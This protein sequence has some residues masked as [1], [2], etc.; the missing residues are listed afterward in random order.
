MD[1]T[2]LISWLALAGTLLIVALLLCRLIQPYDI[3]W[4]LSNREDKSNLSKM[5]L[6][7]ANGYLM[8]SGSEILLG[9]TGSF[10]RFDSVDRDYR[11]QYGPV[12]SATAVPPWHRS[13]DD[14]DIPPQPLRP[15]P[16]PREAKMSR[17]K[18]IHRQ[19]SEPDSSA[20][21]IIISPI[22]RPVPRKQHSAPLSF[23]LPLLGSPR[24]KRTT[25]G[26]VVPSPPVHAPCTNPF[27]GGAPFTE[28][29]GEGL[30]PNATT[31]TPTKP[32][33]GSVLRAVT[34]APPAQLFAPSAA[35]PASPQRTAAHPVLRAPL[36]SAN[37]PFV[38]ASSTPTLLKQSIGNQTNQYRHQ[39][40]QQQQ[41]CVFSFEPATVQSLYTEDDPLRRA[42]KR[43]STMENLRRMSRLIES[44]QL[45]LNIYQ[46]FNRT[47]SEPHPEPPPSVGTPAP[48][49]PPPPQAAP[50]AVPGGGE[51]ASNA[52]RS[53]PSV[54]LANER[55]PPGPAAG[56]PVPPG[57][58]RYR[59]SPRTDAVDSLRVPSVSRSIK[60]ILR[61]R[62]FSETEFSERALAK[63][64]AM[65]SELEPPPSPPA[66]SMMKHSSY[67]DL[68]RYVPG[69]G[70]SG[71]SGR[72]EPSHGQRAA[73]E[74]LHKTVSESF[75]EQYSLLGRCD[76]VPPVR[77]GEPGSEPAGDVGGVACERFRTTTTVLPSSSCESV[78]S[79]SSVVFAD[80]TPSSLHRG[81]LCVALQPDR[82]GTSGGTEL[83]VTVQEAKDLVRPAGPSDAGEMETFV[84]VFMSTDKANAVQTKIC[85]GSSRPSYGETFRFRIPANGGTGRRQTLCFQVYQN[86]AQS[87]TLVGEA[88]AQINDTSQQWPTTTWLQLRDCSY[89]KG[90][91][92]GE[93]MF[94][95]SYLPTAER[96]TVVVVKA[97][98][99]ALKSR[100]VDNGRRGI[101]HCNEPAALDGP[102][103]AT[104][105]AGPDPECGGNIFVKVYLLQ[106]DQK[107][108]KK[109]TSAK[110]AEQFP[111]YNEAIIFSVPP[112][113]LNAV[114]IRLSV[115]QMVARAESSAFPGDCVD[116]AGYRRKPSVKLVSLGHVIIG[117]GTT[118][119]ALRHWHQ[120]LT[121]LR[122]PVAMWHGLRS[123]SERKQ[124]RSG[125]G[126]T[127]HKHDQLPA[128]A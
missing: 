92:L 103:A 66:A 24:E 18:P 59:D 22:P 52:D 112:Y 69:V 9:S 68:S 42:E 6:Y 90:S 15:A 80:L 124:S 3:A 13:T 110:R 77:P 63:T 127:D 36:H 113:L 4:F 98:N 17:D 96:L 83:A 26:P 71:S 1:T 99:I 10:R 88:E 89:Q 11:P 12:P 72:V 8:R 70:T 91:H 87:P 29:C 114:Q 5:R 100:I 120:M 49:T 105:I 126:G 46:Q 57:L 101:V 45:L 28:E 118:G 79:Q 14:P 107:V 64:L 23:P 111:I 81:Y 2:V 58:A 47:V 43:L 119:K 50:P 60:H 54:S 106:N 37:N 62:S 27:L 95:L 122:K 16:S 34:I 31:R 74:T 41:A 51:P 20:R 44:N 73:S 61:N 125:A 121:A 33:P 35:T 56:E 21:S 115:V 109:K 117:S 123:T 128:D 30:G 39:Q 65:L 76:G 93:L 85:A 67:R 38:D 48:P 86:D 94:S 32:V 97:R 40:Q 55:P 82:S 116:R 25:H 102:S 104:D 19:T 108:S 7:N 78:A 53:R 84:R 75:L